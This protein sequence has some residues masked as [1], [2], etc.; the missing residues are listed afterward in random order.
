M[1]SLKL[2]I[3]LHTHQVGTNTWSGTKVIPGSFARSLIP[4]LNDGAAT[5]KEVMTIL[6]NV[7]IIN[8][9]TFK[10]TLQIISS[11]TG[12]DTEDYLLFQGRYTMGQGRREGGMGAVT[13]MIWPPPPFFFSSCQLRAQSCTL[14]I[15]IPLSHYDN[16]ATTFFRKQKVCRRSPPTP[17]KQRISLCVYAHVFSRVSL[18]A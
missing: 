7:S 6:C 5:L 14:M 17:H 2:E 16:F 8:A 12:V 10:S 18:L 9:A 1:T 11:A 3:R 4:D 13:P 15:I